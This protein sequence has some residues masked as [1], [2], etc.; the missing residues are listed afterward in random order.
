M[1]LHFSDALNDHFD[2]SVNPVVI[3]VTDDNERERCCIA[4]NYTVSEDLEEADSDDGSHSYR[5]EGNKVIEGAS[6]HLPQASAILQVTKPF[7]E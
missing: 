1:I 5:G 3:N 4:Y 6:F 2:I 7:A